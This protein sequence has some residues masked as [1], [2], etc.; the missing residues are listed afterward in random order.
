MENNE[1]LMKLLI[2]IIL[3]LMQV[4][5]VNTIIDVFMP[6]VSRVYSGLELTFVKDSVLFYV[7]RTLWVLLFLNM[8]QLY[9]MLYAHVNKD[10]VNKYRCVQFWILTG[11]SFCLLSQGRTLSKDRN[12]YRTFFGVQQE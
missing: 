1:L 8:F 4:V 11:D 5:I 9:H 6:H 2:S 12:Y 7:R 10:I 3:R